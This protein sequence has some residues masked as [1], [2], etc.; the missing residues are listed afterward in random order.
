MTL[1][2]TTKPA[3][4]PDDAE[5]LLAERF[6]ITGTLRVLDGYRDLN[7]RVDADDGRRFVFKI[8]N[9]LEARAYIDLQDVALRRLADAGIEGCPQPTLPRINSGGLDDRICNTLICVC[10]ST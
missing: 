3:L 2:A 4:T 6:G 10:A 7:F 1:P 5:A 8:Y 9:P